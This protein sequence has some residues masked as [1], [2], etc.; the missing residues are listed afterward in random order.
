MYMIILSRQAHIFIARHLWKIWNFKTV[1]LS[2]HLIFK[3]CINSPPGYRHKS[4]FTISAKLPLC[5]VF[6]VYHR[7]VFMPLPSCVYITWSEWITWLASKR[8][9][10]ISSI[11]Y[12]I[13][14]SSTAIVLTNGFQK[15]IA[16]FYNLLSKYFIWCSSF[17][18]FRIAGFLFVKLIYFWWKT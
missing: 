1:G 8:W 11:Y 2:L 7:L 10:N 14:L 5:P 15:I 3:I 18:K 4:P 16:W 12:K 9:E 6:V 13:Q 17:L